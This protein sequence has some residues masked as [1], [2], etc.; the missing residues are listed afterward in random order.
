MS[1]EKLRVVAVAIRDK[2]GKIY[3]L[4]APARHHNVI[5][6]MARDGLE[7]MG[8]DIEQG[9]L[10]SDGQF[11]RRRAAKFIAAE[12]GQLLPRAM[13]LDELFSEDVW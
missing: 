4:P 5:H 2:E 7:T 3:T 9:F 1:E 12:A 11:C 10:L 13:D 6:K 8:P